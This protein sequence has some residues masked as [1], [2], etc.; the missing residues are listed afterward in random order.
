MS[1]LNQEQAEANAIPSPS[2]PRKTARKPRSI[3]PCNFRAAGR[4]SNETARALTA[5]HETLAR[6]LTD[7][8]CGYVGTDLTV[9][10]LE[11]DQFPVKEHIANIPRFSYIASF[12]VSPISDS[13]VL[14]CDIDLVFP[15][16]DLLLG[17][18]GVSRREARELSEIEQEI[19]QDLALLIARQTASAWGTPGLTVS[20]TSRVEPDALQEAFPAN[21][22]VTAVKFEME[23]ES[24]TGIFE[25]VF[26]TSLVAV[27]IKQSKAGQPQKKGALRFFPTTS[28]RERILDCDVVVAADL[29]S[30][31]V[32]VRDLVALQPGYVLKL[33]APVKTPGM[34]TVAGREIFEA[35]PVRNG[36]QKAAQIGRRV[37]LTS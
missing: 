17:G 11:L 23:M 2:H 24:A 22:K 1:A 18:S 19:M 12:P 30:M 28:L 20:A 3:Q 13:V 34:L 14:E 10:L 9:K 35:V 33:R 36:A 31:K 15:I 4:L 27:L 16:I 32:S 25:L 37:Q 8:L 7:A 5:M 6:N 26:P 21:E 29:P